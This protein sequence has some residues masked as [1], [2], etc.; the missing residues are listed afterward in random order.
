MSTAAATA[1]DPNE[2]TPE[3]AQALGQLIGQN[4]DKVFTAEQ[5]M[6][7]GELVFMHSIKMLSEDQ[8]DQ[9]IPM[10]PAEHREA[11]AHFIACLRQ[12]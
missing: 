12:D 3:L 8:L 2:M 6:A 4:V 9:L 7:L 11:A 1:Y 5:K 10:L